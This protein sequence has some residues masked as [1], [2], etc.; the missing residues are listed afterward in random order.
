M[1]NA[2]N[3]LDWRSIF[4]NR[5][6]GPSARVCFPSRQRRG[7]GVEGKAGLGLVGVGKGV[8]GGWEGEEGLG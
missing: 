3:F 7:N 8:S 1:S 4:P 5:R 6:L 2:E